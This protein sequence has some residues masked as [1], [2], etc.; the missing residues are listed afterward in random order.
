MTEMEEGTSTPP[1]KSEGKDA[2]GPSRKRSHSELHHDHDHTRSSFSSLLKT[3]RISPSGSPPHS[4]LQDEDKDKDKDSSKDTD[5]D[6]DSTGDKDLNDT[7]VRAPSNS[8]S[9]SSGSHDYDHSGSA[10]DRAVSLD[11]EASSEQG[12]DAQGGTE[13]GTE[14][15]HVET[16]SLQVMDNVKS[17]QAIEQTCSSFSSSSSS[18]CFASATSYSSSPSWPSHLHGASTGDGEGGVHPHVLSAHRGMG[19]TP[20]EREEEEWR[21]YVKAQ[22]WEEWVKEQE[23]IR[24]LEAEQVQK[25]NDESQRRARQELQKRVEAWA[26]AFPDPSL[27]GTSPTTPEQKQELIERARMEYE[28]GWRKLEDELVPVTMDT[29]PWLPLV[30]ATSGS[31]SS[32]LSSPSSS[33]SSPSSSPPSSSP[34]S[35]SGSTTP[36]VRVGTT[37]ASGLS[38]LEFLFH[39]TSPEEKDVRRN[40][41]KK[42]LDK[43]Q[44]G[45]FIQ[46]FGPRLKEQNE[47]AAGE[48]KEP[49]QSEDI[50]VMATKVAKALEGIMEQL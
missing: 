4:S 10:H 8:S 45:N 23:R 5:K 42:E 3:R 15:H 7:K 27:E 22:G 24:C 25:Q 6:K 34:S 11:R 17:F 31:G 47:V 32:S 19:P 21:A 13:E 49:C 46:R 20:E 2:S 48:G 18:S 26:H 14:V 50:I 35:P 1:Q 43:F 36:T 38:L 40:L 39:G 12:E 44:P 41:L 29:I 30:P 28:E 37:P 16:N 33:S 9:S